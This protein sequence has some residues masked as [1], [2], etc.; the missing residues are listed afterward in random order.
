MSRLIKSNVFQILIE[1]ILRNF[2]DLLQESSSIPDNTFYKQLDGVAIASP[3]SFTLANSFLCY[4]EKRRLDKYIKEFK[5]VFYRQYV[6]GIFVFFIRK[7][8]LHYFLNY[9]NSCHKYIKFT[10]V[11]KNQRPAT[12]SRH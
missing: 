6:G 4:H 9:F 8:T 2:R 10:A 5:P 1:P 12:V 11:K 3:L 7:I